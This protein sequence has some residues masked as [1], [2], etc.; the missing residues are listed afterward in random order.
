MTY[1]RFFSSSSTWLAV[2]RGAHDAGRK[3]R[4]KEGRMEG[5]I[6]LAFTCSDDSR[7]LS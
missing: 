5:R 1:I 2:G 6:G 3:E 4:G 7:V